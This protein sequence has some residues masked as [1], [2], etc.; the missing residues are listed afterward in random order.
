MIKRTP[1]QVI[2][3]RENVVVI[4]VWE[5]IGTWTWV[6]A[7]IDARDIIEGNSL[8]LGDSVWAMKGGESKK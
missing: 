1:V 3:G 5:I 8:R 2:K 6:V 4:Q 7:E